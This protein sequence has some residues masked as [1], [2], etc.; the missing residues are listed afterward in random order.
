[1]EISSKRLRRISA[2]EQTAVLQRLGEMVA[3]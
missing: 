1:M 3:E 2:D